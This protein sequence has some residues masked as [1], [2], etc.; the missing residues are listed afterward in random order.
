[1]RLFISLNEEVEKEESPEPSA[2][3]APDSGATQQTHN[4]PPPKKKGPVKQQANPKSLPKVV[5]DESQNYL[6]LINRHSVFDLTTDDLSD[7]SFFI[8]RTSITLKLKETDS[9]SPNKTIVV[10]LDTVVNQKQFLSFL[11]SNGA[12]KG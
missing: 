5:K 8:K 9:K 1:M 6:S 3:T 4:L 2:Q 12:H 10:P 7:Y 11:E